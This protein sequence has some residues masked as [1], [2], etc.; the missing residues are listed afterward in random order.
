[1]AYGRAQRAQR[2]GLRTRIGHAK[3]VLGDDDGASRVAILYGPLTL[4]HADAGDQIGAVGLAGEP[5]RSLG[6]DVAIARPADIVA[7]ERCELGPVRLSA[8]QLDAQLATGHLAVG[9]D[10]AQLALDDSEYLARAERRIVATKHAQK[11]RPVPG[12]LRVDL[13]S[14]GRCRSDASSPQRGRGACAEQA[15]AVGRFH[16]FDVS[17]LAVYRLTA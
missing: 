2:A 10:T 8:Q 16:V 9:G 11:I 7:Q 6:E 1:M 4:P 13:A 3:R 14:R 17:C 5:Q 12:K 15:P